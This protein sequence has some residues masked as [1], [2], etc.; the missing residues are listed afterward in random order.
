MFSVGSTCMT[1]IQAM[2]Q[3]SSHQQVICQQY[4]NKSTKEITLKWS[5]LEKVSTIWNIDQQWCTQWSRRK[6]RRAPLLRGLFW[7]DFPR[8]W[9]L[10]GNPKCYMIFESMSQGLFL[11]FFLKGSSH[12]LQGGALALY[13]CLTCPRKLAGVACLSGLNDKY[14][15]QIYYCLSGF[16]SHVILSHPRLAPGSMGVR[17]RGEPSHH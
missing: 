11:V 4:S 12:I 15:D 16:S 14:I 1:H 17:K 13:A 8:W 9:A 5:Q 7:V 6:F 3:S 2:L 10:I